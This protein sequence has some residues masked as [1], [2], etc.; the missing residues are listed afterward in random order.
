[1]NYEELLFKTF[2]DFCKRAD[3][4][5]L[6]F[7]KAMNDPSFNYLNYKR[8]IYNEH[9]FCK[10]EY[11]DYLVKDAIWEWLMSYEYEKKSKEDLY[12]LL[13]WVGKD[14]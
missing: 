13:S 3:V 10:G 9:K 7:K 6:N 8:Y 11:R 12:K 14:S 4:I 2:N 1:M 5:L